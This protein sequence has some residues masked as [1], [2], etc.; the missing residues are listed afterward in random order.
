MN[1]PINTPTT[2][3]GTLTAGF[4]RDGWRQPLGPPTVVIPPLIIALDRWVDEGG[5]GDDPDDT[6]WL[7]QTCIPPHREDQ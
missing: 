3:Y 2:G 5:S 7:N 6:A 4:N 1:T